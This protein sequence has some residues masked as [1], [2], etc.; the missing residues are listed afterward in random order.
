LAEEPRFL[1]EEPRFLAE[2]PG[3]EFDGPPNEFEHDVAV[4]RDLSRRGV[5][6][7]ALA[8]RR[9]RATTRPAW[10]LPYGKGVVAS[11]RP[12]SAAA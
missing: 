1:A 6:A 5:S 8:R 11:A 10:P 3:S 4:D 9:F 2:E 7:I 12:A